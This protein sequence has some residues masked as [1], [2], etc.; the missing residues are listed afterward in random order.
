MA[1]AP[2]VLIIGGGP[3]GAALGGLLSMRGRRSVIIERERFPRFHIGES[4]LPQSMQVFEELGV[5]DQLEERFIRKYGA[6]FVEATSG[7]MVRYEFAE[8]VDKRWPY[9]YEVQR[10]VFDELLLDRARELGATVLQP[11]RVTEV[12]FDDERAVGVV[13]A[14]EDGERELRAPLVVDATGRGSLLASRSKTKDRIAGL[15][16]A[17]LFSHYRG[18]P[19]YE[20]NCEGD[21]TV[22]TFDDGWIWFI[23]LRG[24]VTSVGAVL[25][26]E[27]FASRP[28]DESYESFLERVLSSIPWA[29]DRLAGAERLMDV[30][31][32]ADFS[33]SVER[34]AGDG[35]LAIGD[36]FGFIDPLFSSGVHL[37]LTTAQLSADAIDEALA[38]GPVTAA[39]FAEVER[40]VRKASEMFLGIVLGNYHG[41]LNEYLYARN[42]RKVL[43]QCI[44]S[45]LSG[46]VFHSDPAPTW[47]RFMREHFSARSVAPAD[48]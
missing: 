12:L 23:P 40:N 7:H 5:V 48:R 6:R 19:R 22:V 25:V 39:H 3:A 32:A 47:A 18:V 31:T 1:A 38:D 4:L 46:D 28:S 11:A 30:Q 36:A 13:V 9:A 16:T 34:M 35:W 45:L 21:I 42:Q 2:E 43:R 17:A 27:R 37:A 33:Y 24:D 14:D 10:D 8:A 29:K 26:K 20:G 44:T 41:S 15:N